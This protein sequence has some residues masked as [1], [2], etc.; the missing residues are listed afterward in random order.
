MLVYNSNGWDRAML[1]LTKRGISGVSKRDQALTY[2]IYEENSPRD[3]V[4][5]LLQFKASDV[6]LDG[7]VES[8]FIFR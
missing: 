7:K 4:C 8:E 6:V 5:L 3:S 2:I 1:Y